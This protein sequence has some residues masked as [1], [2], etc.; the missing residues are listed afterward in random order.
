MVVEEDGYMQDSNILTQIQSMVDEEHQL[1]ERAA[2]GQATDEDHTRLDALRVGLDQCW[3]L[4]R[5]RR[6]LREFGENPDEAQLRD[7]NT[8]ERYEE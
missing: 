3:D 4:L 5:Q 2:Q 6:A 8:V 1:L 7:A